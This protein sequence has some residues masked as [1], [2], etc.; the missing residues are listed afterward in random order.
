MLLEFSPI[1]EIIIVVTI[2]AIKAPTTLLATRIAPKNF[3]GL[4]KIFNMLLAALDPSDARRLSFMMLEAIIDVSEA[5]V[6]AAINSNIISKIIS[7][8]IFI[9]I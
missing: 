1:K 6:K 3:S 2:A 8:V 4:S 5:A 7:N 9:W